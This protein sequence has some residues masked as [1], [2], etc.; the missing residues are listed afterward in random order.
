MPNANIELT[1]YAGGVV[2]AMI[3]LGYAKTKTEAIRLA[4]YQFDQDHGLEDEMAFENLAGKVLDG[5]ETGK[6]K[7]RK[8]KPSELD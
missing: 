8:F 1:G 5:V 4:L 3:R 2:D 7:T 6:I